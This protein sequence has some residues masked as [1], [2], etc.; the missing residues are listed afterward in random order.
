MPVDSAAKFV[1]QAPVQLPALPSFGKARP[2]DEAATNPG[3]LAFRDTLIAIVARRD[4]AALHAR[5]APTIKYSFGDSEGGADGMF[6][7]WRQYQ[8]M[9][10]LW[11]TLQDVLT[12]GG[13]LTGPDAFNAPWTAGP[14]L[15]DSIDAFEHL[16]VRDSSVVVRATANA[17]DPG[18]GT[19][20]YDIVRASGELPDSLWRGIKLPDGRAGYV[21]SRHIRSP[22]EWRM[23]L[24]RY[25]S[26][27]LIDF[28]VAGD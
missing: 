9:D 23:G 12:H 11:I 17:A 7:Y 3:L 24:R 16:V 26:R 27:W 8:S 25:G 5:I 10:E 2:V 13:R 20:S 18:F 1:E 21:E 19:L 14:V 22:I 4:S 15:P 28:F 6:R